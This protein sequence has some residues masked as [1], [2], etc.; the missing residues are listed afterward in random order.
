MDYRKKGPL[1][2]M[3]GLVEWTGIARFARQEPRMRRLKWS[4]VFLLALA[5]AG[6]AAPFI[7]P[8]GYV[9]ICICSSLSGTVIAIS[10]GLSQIGP[11]R[12]MKPE[13]SDDEREQLWRTR[14]YLFA[15]GAIGLV[16]FLGTFSLGGFALWSGLSGWR[17]RSP[18]P[19]L[20]TYGY[21]LVTLGEYLVALF[22][23][24]PTLHA[25]WTMPEIIE[26]EPES[27][28]GLRFVKSPRR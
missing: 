6:L 18:L 23:I 3:D 14:S 11:M 16:A 1:Q 27:E 28:G 4:P 25:S 17:V 5:T 13:E 22:A 24:L 19:P 2:W 9:V 26:D 12:P 20:E 10:A 7:I 15:F 8:P 21:W